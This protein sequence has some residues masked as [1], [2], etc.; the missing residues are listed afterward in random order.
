MGLSATPNQTGILGSVDVSLE[1][2]SGWLLI[3][4]ATLGLLA[5]LPA[6][7]QATDVLVLGRAGH[8]TVRD[9]PLVKSIALTPTPAAADLRAPEVPAR[10]ASTGRTVRSELARLLRSNAISLIAYDDYLG[11]FNAALR[12]EGHLP[13]TRAVE[14]EDVTENLHDIAANGLLSASRLPAL[15]LTLQRNM[16]WWATGPLLSYGQR[17]EFAGSELVWEYY[18]GQG[19]ELQELGSFGKADWFCTAGPADHAQ[20]REMLA[21]LIP[22]AAQRAG[23]L[24]WEYYF[25]FDGGSPPWTSA[26]SQG[27]ALQTLADAYSALGDQSFLTIGQ[28]ALPIFSAAPP[29]GVAVKTRLGT[30][31]LQYSFAP[32]PDEN[33]INGFLQSLIGLDDF[34]HVSGSPEAAQLF[35]AGDA[36]AI[37]EVPQFDIGGWSLYQPGVDD[38]LSYQELVTAFLQQLCEMTHTPVYCNTATSFNSY[39]TTRPVLQL[40]TQR[41]QANRPLTIAFD[42]SKLSRVGITVIRDGNT[43]FLTSADFNGGSHTFALGALTEAGTYVVRLDATDLAGNYAQI[44]DDLSV[45]G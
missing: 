44:A 17:V 9:D 7:A 15:F 27:T 19:I 42:V 3:A 30:R 16:Q 31:Y 10:F 45:T 1:R 25:S 12:E 5:G 36:E 43:L 34:A 38:D 32:A 6:R 14:L 8:V 28:E 11:I 23:G 18:P 26:M 21:E 35:A 33:V 29:A 13:A 4:I 24:T 40:L 37:A 22:L 2:L 20:C 39:L 41:A